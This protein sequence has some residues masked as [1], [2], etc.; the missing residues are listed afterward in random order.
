MKSIQSIQDLHDYVV[1]LVGDE[2]RAAKLLSS[3]TLGGCLTYTLEQVQIKYRSMVI[4]E[5]TEGQNVTVKPLAFNIFLLIDNEHD[6]E[7][8]ICVI[9]EDGKIEF[10]VK[11]V[12]YD[13]LH[14][15]INC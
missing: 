1:E 14:D 13:N 9:G 10:Y 2:E 5:I 8:S 7:P 6:N 12:E 11:Q 4:D 15:Y 3:I